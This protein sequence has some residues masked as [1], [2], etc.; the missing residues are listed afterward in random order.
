VDSFASELRRCEA[1]AST[2]SCRTRNYIDDR[3]ARASRANADGIAEALDRVPGGRVLCLE[4]TA[5]PGT[6]LGARSRSC[7]AIIAA[8]ARRDAARLAVCVDTCHV[9]SAG[10]DLVNDY[11]GVIAPASTTR[12]GLD[13]CACGI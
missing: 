11:E 9:Y 3:D 2:T 12:S 13:G 10:Y 6:A 5:G 1:L 7:G 4:T 8:A